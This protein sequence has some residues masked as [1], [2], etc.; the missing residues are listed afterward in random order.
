[1]RAASTYSSDFTEEGMQRL[2]KGALDLTRVT[3]E[4]PY[5]GLPE[6]SQLGSLSGDLRLYHED[7]Y[8]LPPEERI[9]YARR[10]ENAALSADPRIKSSDG[11]SFDASAGRKVL[12]NSLGF[13]GDYRRSTCSV[14]AMPIAQAEDGSMQRDGWSSVA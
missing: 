8:S 13:I 12:A 6:P 7:V 14:T 4:D 2:V 1:R 11:G 10:A 9:E 5:A 3:S